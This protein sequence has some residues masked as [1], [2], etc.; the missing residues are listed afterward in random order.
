MIV[1]I[2]KLIKTTIVAEKKARQLAE[3]RKDEPTWTSYLDEARRQRQ[4]WQYVHYLVAGVDVQCGEGRERKEVEIS[5][6]DL[7]Q[8]LAEAEWEKA[9]LC[10]DISGRL[11]GA[12]KQAVSQVFRQAL[13]YSSE[14]LAMAQDELIRQTAD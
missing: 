14:F 3:I 4:L 7:L 11:D 9:K 5:R 1:P 13:R 8:S 6:F 2:Q 10:Q 12:A